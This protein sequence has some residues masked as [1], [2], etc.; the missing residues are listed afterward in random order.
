MGWTHCDGYVRGL[1]VAAVCLA[2]SAAETPRPEVRQW[3]FRVFLDGKP[4][5]SH[6]FTL[7]TRNGLRELTSEAEFTVRVLRIPVYR[8]SHRALEIWRGD[9]LISLQASTV[10][11]DVRQAVEARLEGGTFTVVSGTQRDLHAPPVLSFAYWNP[12]I[13]GAQRLLNAQTGRLEVVRIEAMGPGTVLD[14]RGQTRSAQQYRIHG[15]DQPIT[16][17]YGQDGDWLGLASEVDGRQLT[18]RLEQE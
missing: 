9:A 2:G 10:D 5:G 4:I 12:A 1:A 14:A 13:L 6:R 18:Y 7:R 3:P 16:V 15:P 17:W 11:G 8:Y